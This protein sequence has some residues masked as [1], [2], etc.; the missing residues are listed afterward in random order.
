MS[1]GL[2]KIQREILLV[3]RRRH[4][5]PRRRRGAFVFEIVE[6]GVGFAVRGHDD[7]KYMAYYRAIRSLERRGLLE[8]WHEVHSSPDDRYA[9]WVM[10]DHR[11]K[12]VALTA[13]GVLEKR[14]IRKSIHA[15]VYT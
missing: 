11:V 7:G 2:G 13:G 3:C 9:P 4:R 15:H 5:R 6:G 14:R 1:R 12:V 8:S 10:S